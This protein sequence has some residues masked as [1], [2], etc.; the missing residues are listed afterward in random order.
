MKNINS[1]NFCKLTNNGFMGFHNNAVAVAETITLKDV[2]AQLEIYK[3]SIRKFADY[4]T[5]ISEANAKKEASL[6]DSNRTGAF[7]KFRQLVRAMA[8]LPGTTGSM[9]SEMWDFLK[10][11]SP[12]TDQKR[13]TGII[14]STL[15]NIRTVITKEQ[16]AQV[17][18]GSD[19]E[20]CF[21]ALQESQK[22]FD[23][24]SLTRLEERKLREQ[25]TNRELRDSCIDGF[26]NV[27]NVIQ[28][29]A[30]TKGDESCQGA[31]DKVNILIE[32]SVSL[33]KSRDKARAAKAAKSETDTAPGSTEVTSFDKVNSNAA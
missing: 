19:L 30:I 12:H 7:V 26:R 25:A 29:N 33:Y 31:I 1:I 16:Y 10:N 21:N 2:Q 23:D 28:Y 13:L 9:A 6:Q 8:N 14:D 22:A 11:S 24:A 32:K 3:A 27:M 4:A 15:D 20:T 5:S 17:F 18:E